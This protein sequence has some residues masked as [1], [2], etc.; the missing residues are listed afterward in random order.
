MSGCHRGFRCR[1]SGSR[2]RVA[3]L[4]EIERTIP[5]SRPASG[6][7][8]RAGLVQDAACGTGAQRRLVL[9]K[10][11]HGAMLVQVGPASSSTAT[12]SRVLPVMPGDR[13]EL[14]EYHSEAMW[15]RSAG[16]ADSQ[17][18]SCCDDQLNPP[19]TSRSNTPSAWPKP[20]SSRRFGS[21]GDSYDNALAETINGLY[22]TEVIH[23]RGPWRS[24]QAVEYATLE[25]VDWFN[26]RRLLE[27][28]GN[29]PPAEAEARYY[30][31]AEGHA[32]AA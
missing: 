5:R 29:I 30:A 32:I 28:I 22:K 18:R 2:T 23:R 21:V 20:A 19:N 14:V 7:A 3:F 31:Q 11:E 13:N 9:D 12:P 10:T 26:N 1:L 15:C 8:P 25:W 24:L 17:Q 4:G 16:S 6:R 27:P